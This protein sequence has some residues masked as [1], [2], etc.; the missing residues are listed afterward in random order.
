M[1]VNVVAALRAFG[2]SKAG[3]PLLMAS[4]PVRAVQPEANARTRSRARPS[5]ARLEVPTTG[6]AAVGAA[7]RPAVAARTA[8]Q[9]NISSVSPTKA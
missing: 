8:A 9:P 3:T 4:T 7:G 1:S 5:P 6:C 2:F